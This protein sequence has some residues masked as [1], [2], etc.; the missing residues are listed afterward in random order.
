MNTLATSP[1]ELVYLTWYT[2]FTDA[3]DDQFANAGAKINVQFPHKNNKVNKLSTQITEITYYLFSDLISEFGGSLKSYQMLFSQPLM[4]F[5]ILQ[6]VKI[7][8]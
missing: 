7:I 5:F 6:A 3:Q 4:P 1:I 8:A 2:N